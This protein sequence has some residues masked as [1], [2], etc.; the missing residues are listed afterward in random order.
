VP[1][2]PV[3]LELSGPRGTLAMVLTRVRT[4]DSIDSSVHSTLA[5]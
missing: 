4:L 5:W 3:Y 2:I 1:P